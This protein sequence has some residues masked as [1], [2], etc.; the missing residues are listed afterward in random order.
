MSHNSISSNTE[1]A[2]SYWTRMFQTYPH[3][4][5]PTIHSLSNHFRVLPFPNTSYNA[6]ARATSSLHIPLCMILQGKKDENLCYY[7]LRSFIWASISGRRE[8]VALSGMKLYKKRVWIVSNNT[9]PKLL[10]LLIIS[11]LLCTHLQGAVI[12]LGGN[13]LIFRDRK[14]CGVSYVKSKC[15]QE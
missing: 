8:K 7:L 15:C 9:T 3:R 12:F 6:I 4:S 11:G 1:T 10:F 2:I 13:L 14:S 5:Y